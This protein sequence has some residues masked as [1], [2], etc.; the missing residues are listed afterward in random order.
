MANIFRK[1]G[2]W[3]YALNIFGLVILVK[4]AHGFVTDT[5]ENT[6]LNGIALVVAILCLAA[7]LTIVEIAKNKGNSIKKVVQR[8]PSKNATDE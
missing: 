1:Y 2:I 3:E 5:I 8:K 4:L 6:A 7:P